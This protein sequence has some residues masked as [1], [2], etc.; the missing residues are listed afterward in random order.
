MTRTLLAA[1]PLAALAACGSSPPAPPVAAPPG[2]AAPSATAGSS[3]AGVAASSASSSPGTPAPGAQHPD[4]TAASAASPGGGAASPAAGEVALRGLLPVPGDMAPDWTADP[5]AEADGNAG[6]PH[7]YC[8]GAFG[9]DRDRTA[10]ASVVLR[11]T[12][13]AHG[14]F[15]EA[16]RYAGDRVGEALEDYREAFR[17]CRSYRS[18]SAKVTG[19]DLAVTG[20][21]AILFEIVQDGRVLYSAVVVRRAGDVVLSGTVFGVDRGRVEADAARVGGV[22]VRR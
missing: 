5:V 21:D 1:I 12:V 6:A 22:W 2:A 11:S 17:D 14:V 16:T 20:T 9:S 3:A 7:E 10:R 15:A 19:H 4:G 8:D 18:G 13:P